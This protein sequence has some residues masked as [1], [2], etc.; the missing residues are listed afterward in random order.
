M[1]PRFGPGL[2]AFPTLL[3]GLGLIAAPGLA[4]AQN[5]PK[6]PPQPQ[7]KPAAPDDRAADRTAVEA[8]MQSFVKSFESADAK[9]VADHW[10]AE[11][12]Y[13][14]EDGTIIRGRDA[15]VKGF[16]AFFAKN[17]KVEVRLQPDSL[18][19]LSAVNAIQEGRVTI[20]RGPSEPSVA[21]QYSALFV[22]EDRSWKI[23]R[24]QEETIDE[25][26]LQD[27]DWLIGEWKSLGDQAAEVLT[28]Y[29]WDENRKFLRVRFTIKEKDRTLSGFQ[30]LGK[31]PATGDIRAWTFEAEGGIGEAVWVRDGDHWVAEATGTLT[32][33]RTLTA[34]NILRRI[35]N[36]TFTWQSINRS[37]DDD[38]IPDLPPVKVTRVKAK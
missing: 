23:A 19:F 5:A 7:P 25:A 27:L 30:V 10:T 24:L 4:R 16:T 15:L 36:D 32:D 17:P 29:S 1:K 34:T 8:A 38:E 9:A 22:R 6:P 28:T 13:Q 3:I 2:V 12:E 33:G 26:T 20:R 35:N 18:R 11:G 21:A 14:G 37:I 31:D